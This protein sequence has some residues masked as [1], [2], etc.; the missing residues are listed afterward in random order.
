VKLQ[1]RTIVVL[2]WLIWPLTN[3]MGS[4]TRVHWTC[5][6]YFDIDVQETFFS[7]APVIAW[8]NGRFVHYSSFFWTSIL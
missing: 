5:I 3:L 2:C 1:L 4:D 7:V 8:R 6:Y